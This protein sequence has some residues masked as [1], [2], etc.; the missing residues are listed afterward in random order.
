MNIEDFAEVMTWADEWRSE[1]PVDP[2]NAGVEETI[3]H[4]LSCWL[5]QYCGWDCC[6]TAEAHGMIDWKALPL[7]T[8]EWVAFLKKVREQ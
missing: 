7:R 5:V 1:D 8:D 4:M 6:G 3:S 2:Y